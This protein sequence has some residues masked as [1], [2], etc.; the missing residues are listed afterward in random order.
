MKSR[1]VVYGGHDTWLKAM[2]GYV[3]GDIRFIDKDQ[4][5]LDRSVIR[6]ADAVWIQHNALSHKQY[7][8]VIDE[9]RKWDKP[10]HYFMY[11][12]AKKCVEQIAREEE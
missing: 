11:A 1:L 7:Y 2:K 3:N 4:G 5:I 9:V 12:S 6:N 10:V 8:A